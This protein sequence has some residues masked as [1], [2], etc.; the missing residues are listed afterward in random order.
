MLIERRLQK[1]ILISE[2]QFGFILY[3][4]TVK[5][6]YLL[7]R[8]MELYKARKEDLHLV[9]KDLEKAYD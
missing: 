1:D 8:F 2:N 4:L 9:F 3:R 7:K 5:A 6:I